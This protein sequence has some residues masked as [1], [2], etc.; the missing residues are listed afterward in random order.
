LVSPLRLSRPLDPR[1]GAETTESIALRLDLEQKDEKGGRILNPSTQSVNRY[2]SV[3]NSM[4]AI[5]EIKLAENDTKPSMSLGPRD[6]DARVHFRNVGYYQL[7]PILPYP[8][9]TSGLDEFD[10]ANLMVGEFARNGLAFSY[11]EKNTKLGYFNDLPNAPPTE[12]RHVRRT[13]R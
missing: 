2:S 7:V 1:H 5:K 13:I 4:A 10:K 9:S 8:V 3:L 12:Q 11:Q 6:A